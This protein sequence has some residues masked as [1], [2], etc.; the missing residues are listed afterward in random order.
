MTRQLIP[1]VYHARRN[2]AKVVTEIYKQSH[3][4]KKNQYPLDKDV[5]NH[6]CQQ[7]KSKN[8]HS[9]NPKISNNYQSN[10]QNRGGKEK[11]LAGL[12]KYLKGGF[13]VKGNSEANQFANECIAKGITDPEQIK[14]LGKKKGFTLIELLVVIGIIGT[15]AAMLLPALGRAREQGRRATCIN[16]LRQIGVAHEMYRQDYDLKYESMLPHSPLAGKNLH[17]YIYVPGQGPKAH[18]LFDYILARDNTEAKK[19]I[20]YCPSNRDE[21]TDTRESLQYWGNSSTANTVR[22]HYAYAFTDSKKNFF[23]DWEIEAGARRNSNHKY[24]VN[25]L[26]ED[27]HVAT[28]PNT[29]DSS[30]QPK[31]KVT[32]VPSAA[33]SLQRVLDNLDSL[34]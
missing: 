33:E 8:P 7:E 10:Y 14:K 5:Q 2:K 28:Y 22:S 11:G 29:N 31:F 6:P 34:Q 24:V 30:G 3:L 32:G 1:N 17:N 18:G 16:N 19:N 27:G 21:G 12:V 20:Y 9:Y 25:V 15:L 4:N 23:L 13:R 26:F